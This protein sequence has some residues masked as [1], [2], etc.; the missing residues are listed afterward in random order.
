MM[1]LENENVAPENKEKKPQ[2]CSEIAGLNSNLS[3]KL[4]AE[5]VS[6]IN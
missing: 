5:A 1:R 3:R 6:L 2:I 4:H